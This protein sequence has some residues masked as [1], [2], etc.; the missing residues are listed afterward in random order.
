LVPLF[1]FYT[2]VNQ[3]NASGY[4]LLALS[5][6]M[7]A[8]N[9]GERVYIS[10]SVSFMHITGVPYVPQ[11]HLILAGIQHAFLPA[12]AIIGQL[13]E[14]PGPALLLLGDED[15]AQLQR[16]AHLD[17]WPGAASQAAHAQG[18]GLYTLDAAAPLVKP[19]F[20]LT[21]ERAR[22]VQPSRAVD[23]AVGGLRLIG[24]DLPEAIAPGETLSL[25]LY[26][27]ALGAV[28]AGT[29]MGFAHLVDPA[30]NEL[31]AQD[32]HRLGQAQYPVNAWQPGEVV[33]DRYELPVSAAAA[34][35]VVVRI[36]AYT[37]PDLARLPVPGHADN[38]IYLQPVM[39][40]R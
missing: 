38:V 16:V 23:I 3:T 30:T 39:V 32:D 13:F 7:V 4:P 17:P 6:A 21:G 5:R 33:V 8:A 24:Y 40:R 1:Q 36:G 34:E 12:D 19:D 31:L 25:V 14:A 2:F 37:W 15:A 35:E 22:N 9:H 28:P 29:Y 27:E 10:Q 11:L 26:W 18:F 20:V